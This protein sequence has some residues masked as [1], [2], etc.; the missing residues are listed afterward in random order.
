M[1]ALPDTP[2]DRCIQTR[3]QRSQYNNKQ[4]RVFIR[5]GWALPPNAVDSLYN[6]YTSANPSLPGDIKR[7]KE[8]INHAKGRGI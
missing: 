3:T 4:S 2:Y 1:L 5:V 7:I 6:G 8:A